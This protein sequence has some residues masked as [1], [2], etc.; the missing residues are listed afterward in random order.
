M[1]E[2]SDRKRFCSSDCFAASKYLQEQISSTPVWLRDTPK[3]LAEEAH[4]QITLIDMKRT[5]KTETKKSEIKKSDTK[6]SQLD[7]FKEI[8]NELR[9]IEMKWKE[10]YEEKREE[11]R[12]E[13]P[14]E[15]NIYRKI[16][17]DE[18]PTTSER[19]SRMATTTISREQLLADIEKKRKEF[20][21][22]QL[23]QKP[24]ELKL[25]SKILV[26]DEETRLLESNRS[27]YLFVE[28]LLQRLNDL[29]TEKTRD[30]LRNHIYSSGVNCE[31]QE[32]REREQYLEKCD[33]YVTNGALAINSI[34]NALSDDS[35]WSSSSSSNRKRDEQMREMRVASNDQVDLT[36]EERE[37]KSKIEYLESVLSINNAAKSSGSSRNQNN[38]EEC[39]KE[40]NQAAADQL[41]ADEKRPLPDYEKLKEEALVQQLRVREFFQGFSSSSKA[42]KSNEKESATEATVIDLN[43]TSSDLYDIAT[44][45]A[46]GCDYNLNMVIKIK[47]TN[48]EIVRQLPTVDSKSQIV[49]RRKI[50]YEKLIKQ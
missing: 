49:I 25:L 22:A 11:K 50:F 38:D 34:S 5:T 48:E 3:Y 18:R 7:E 6:K 21:T 12:R 40:S 10:K 4:K 32:E 19:P 30:Y 33:K 31:L 29:M 17:V 39:L 13:E 23:F 24:S 28:Y 45:S 43:G 47:E 41:T 27:S 42:N 9:E 2:L 14:I 44:T 36:E 15:N 1:F 8:E 26:D 16:T 20:L 46:F 37:M 35:N